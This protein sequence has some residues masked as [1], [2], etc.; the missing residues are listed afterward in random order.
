MLTSKTIFISIYLLLLK[1]RKFKFTI[2]TTTFFSPWPTPPLLPLHHFYY[3]CRFFAFLL[4]PILTSLFIFAH[5]QFF[6]SANVANVANFATFATFATFAPFAR[7]ISLGSRFAPKERARPERLRV[8]SRVN[9]HVP[10]KSPDMRLNFA[11]QGTWWRVKIE[12]KWKRVVWSNAFTN[13]RWR[14]SSRFKCYEIHASNIPF[15]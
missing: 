3:F 7:W 6:N 14:P 11:K 1:H 9:E 2:A 5:F 8:K 15:A 12:Q 4:L 10:H 13:V